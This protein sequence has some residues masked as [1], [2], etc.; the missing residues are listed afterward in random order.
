MA[1]D[2]AE[3]AAEVTAIL[4]RL[5][6]AVGH[7][8]SGV[9]DRLGDRMIDDTSDATVTWLRRLINRLFV[10]H[11]ENG[12]ADDEDIM[13][14][15]TISHEVA[16]TLQELAVSPDTKS[17]QRLLSLYI[18]D[19]LTADPSLVATVQDLLAQAPGTA[20]GILASP[21]SISTQNSGG[22]NVANTGTI[23]DVNLFGR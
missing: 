16:E 11:P 20:P 18:R 13:P 12:D 17:T 8:A 10:K 14:V 6:P 22:V 3:L 7:T 4:A 1:T 21:A 19:A 9:L 23:G 5:M 2:V 15:D